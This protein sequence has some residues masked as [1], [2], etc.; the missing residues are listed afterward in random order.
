MNR[1]QRLAVVLCLLAVG[2]EAICFIGASSQ[3]DSWASIYL[4]GGA[5]FAWLAIDIAL[6]ARR[7]ARQAARQARWRARKP[8]AQQSR[9][10]ADALEDIR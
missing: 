3:G 10:S 9:H 1:L 7:R 8:L 4:V 2:A 5:W 6:T